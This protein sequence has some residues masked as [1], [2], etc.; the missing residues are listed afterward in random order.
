MKL[1]DGLCAAV[2]EA[3]AHTTIEA[4]TIGLGYTAVAT[5]TG[6]VGLSYT[7]VERTASCSHVRAFRDF[8][9]APAT[10]LLEYVRSDDTLERAMGLA[11]VNALNQPQA[12]QLPDDAGPAGTFVAAFGVREGTRVAMVGFFPPVARRLREIGAQLSVLDRDK[13]MGDEAAFLRDLAEGPDVLIVTA[14]AIL[15][16]SLELFLEHVTE[17]VKVVVL[18]PTTPLVPEAYGALPVHLLAGLVPVDNERVVAAVRQG[19]G[20]P[21]LTP[22]CRKVSWVHPDIAI[23]PGSRSADGGS[24]A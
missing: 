19:A 14:T 20:T 5:A 16:G 3:A 8:D 15:N 24:G 2:A 4:M 9:G 13:R 17:R 11:L 23:T 18:G 7:M 6:C 21:A 12:R 10:E 1:V 22:H